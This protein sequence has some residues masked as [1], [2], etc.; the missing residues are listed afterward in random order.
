MPLW[1]EA[2]PGMIDIFLRHPVRLPNDVVSVFMW[3]PV[4]F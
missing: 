2:S 4:M 3:S 1:G